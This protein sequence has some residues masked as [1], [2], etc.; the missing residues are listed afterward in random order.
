MSHAHVDKFKNNIG[1]YSQE[2][3]VFIKTLWTL[4]VIKNNTMKIRL[5]AIS[6]V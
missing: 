1:A 5:E 4:N 3:D 6:G 2:Q